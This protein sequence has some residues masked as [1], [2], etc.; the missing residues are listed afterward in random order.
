MMMH[1]IDKYMIVAE[2]A[3]RWGLPIDTVKNKLKKSIK[4]N[5]E[6]IAKLEE[7]GLIKYSKHPDSTQGVWIITDDAM[8]KWFG[9]NKNNL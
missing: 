9:E 7:K 8:E 2:A 1:E 6:I 5:V 3:Y 4:G